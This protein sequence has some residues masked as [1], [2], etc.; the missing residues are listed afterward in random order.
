LSEGRKPLRKFGHWTPQYIYDR[1]KLAAYEHAY[2]S[3]PWLTRT[4]VEFL[5]NWLRPEDRGF[6]WG[7]G[8]STIWFAERVASIVSVEHDPEWHRRV[9]AELKGKGIK[10]VDYYL[11]Q[12]EDD[13][14]RVADNC[15][16]AS[17]DFCVVD[18][19]ARDRCALLAL[20]LV[21]PGGIVIVDNCNWYLPTGSR[22][23]FSRK[24]CEG[25]YTEEWA[26]FWKQVEDWRHVWTTN[27]VFD[28][29]LWVK[30]AAL[31]SNCI[32]ES[33]NES[34]RAPLERNLLLQPRVA[35]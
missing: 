35:D 14:C 17:F 15:S 29:A 33:T 24:V 4:M 16:L 22:S 8:R 31:E 12:D 1:L 20:S 6:E 7:S 13:Y 25:A 30:P 26:V 18:G 19:V 27:G 23:P 21:R 34:A 28:T 3:A 10:N 5:A 2:P 32:D 9:S 11:R